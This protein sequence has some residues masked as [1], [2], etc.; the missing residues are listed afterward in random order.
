MRTT[1]RLLGVAGVLA[2]AAG[3]LDINP[4]DHVYGCAKD[5]DCP[6]GYLCDPAVLTCA[7]PGHFVSDRPD[8]AGNADDDMA[9][10]RPPGDYPSVSILSPSADDTTGVN[11]SLKFEADKT[12]VTFHCR[13]DGGEYSD[14]TSPWMLT[15]LSAGTHTADIYATA[16]TVDGP[17]SSVTWKVDATGPQTTISG[18]N[19]HDGDVTKSTTCQFDLASD[20]PGATFECR[21]DSGEFAACSSPF[22]QINLADGAHIFS[23]RAIAGGITGGYASVSWRVDT[24]PPVVDSLN[25]TPLQN[26]YISDTGARVNIT[27]TGHDGD[28]VAGYECK[29]LKDNAVVADWAACTSG[30]YD[31]AGDGLY[32][33]VVRAKDRTGQLS[34]EVTRTFTIDTVKPTLSAITGSPAQGATVN[35]TA[36]DLVFSG[37]DN[38]GVGGYQCQRE[39]TGSWTE[40]QS[41]LR[42]DVS[43]NGAHSVKIRAV[44]YAGNTSAEATRSWTVDTQGPVIA[45]TLTPKDPTA[46]RV[47]TF[48][49]TVSSTSGIQS[50]NC[51]M[52]GANTM[53]C[54][55]GAVTWPSQL[56]AGDHTFTVAATDNAGNLVTRDFKWHIDSCTAPGIAVC[57][58]TV[59]PA[60]GNNGNTGSCTKPLKTI[61]AAFTQIKANEVVCAKPGTYNVSSGETFPITVPTNVSLIGDETGLGSP[62]SATPTQI[63]GYGGSGSLYGVIV[64]SNAV[65]AGF[66]I[67]TSRT[68]TAAGVVPL[69]ATVRKNSIS[70][71]KYGIY[72]V[73]T[74]NNLIS[75]N[76]IYNNSTGINT[77][78]GGATCL[79]SAGRIENNIINDKGNPTLANATGVFLQG[80]GADLGGGAN[81]SVGNN[82]FSCNTNDVYS[83]VNISAT[84]NAW[85]HNP[86]VGPP[87][88]K[89]IGPAATTITV[90]GSKLAA[91]PCN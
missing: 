90:T 76:Q 62:D 20:K 75:G 19:P 38:R 63:I 54:S 78:C 32:A 25:G 86:P 70:N 60:L 22:Q 36:V 5:S 4:A 81:G 33:L 3:C 88:G 31:V 12:G 23:A 65:L 10:V 44:D 37:S 30:Q 59:D 24:M 8:M 91:N 26:A 69:G 34:A 67:Q 43:G 85:D 9:V 13:R 64:S 73:N 41:P 46:Y 61:A 29:Q 87:G 82:T 80:L 89:D 71:S 21:L 52:D 51:S 35:S 7:R 2:G 17:V 74:A 84:N 42:Y 72:I 55:G 27:F 79:A 6:S 40:C 83:T 50:V 57:H 1:F 11:V 66:S 14:C 16:D 48:T 53:G 15:A 49:F 68:D 28:Q 47:A 58:L 39:S 45:F 18:S 56:A 77:T